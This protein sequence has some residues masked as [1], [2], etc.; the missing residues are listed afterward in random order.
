MHDTVFLG[1]IAVRPPLNEAERDYL[2]RLADSNSTL[3]GTPTG[4]GDD[5]VPFAHLAWEPCAAGCCLTWSGRERTKNMQPSL[6]FLV[7]HLLKTGA[8]ADGHKRFGDFTCD[9]VLDGTVVVRRHDDERAYVAEVIANRVGGR[10]VESACERAAEAPSP[11][12]RPRPRP[13]NVID[14]RPRRA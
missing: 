8:R 7:D 13:A 1:R 10:S 14:F 5:N 3:R 11:R 6:R 12:S 9:H 2:T 4:R